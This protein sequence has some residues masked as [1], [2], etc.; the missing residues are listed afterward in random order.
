MVFV[1]KLRRSTSLAAAALLIVASAVPLLS[2]QTAG[3]YTLL[4]E[5]EIKMGTSQ[6]GVV[7]E[8]G[9]RVDFVLTEDVNNLE[10]VVVTF[11]EESP[12]IGEEDC[13]VPAGFDLDGASVTGADE[14]DVDL[15]SFTSDFVNVSNGGSDE[16]TLVLHDDTGVAVDNGDVVTFTIEN[17]NNPTALG[18]FFARIMVYDDDTRALAYNDPGDTESPTLAGGIALST[19][20]V[21][22]I[23]SKVQERL[24][25]CIH[26]NTSPANNPSDCSAPVDP[27]VLGDE[28]GVLSAVDPT[29]SDEA[30]FGITTNA[31]AGATVR[32]KGATLDSGSFTIDPI[33]DTA[34]TSNEGSEQF[35][36]C[37]HELGSPGL[38]ATA[39]YDSSDCSGVT[40][41]Q[42]QGNDNGASFAFDTAQ[43][44]SAYGSSI[45]TKDA[46]QW[47][48][49]VLVFL[50]NISEVTEPGIYTTTLDFIATGRY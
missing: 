4:G 39:P 13:A 37:V 27:V 41:G 15:T 23:E 31:S 36:L 9:Y 7:D 47:S 22:T 49:G 6:T 20:D 34:A 50:G 35:G 38:S 30:R 32:M 45:A 11:C 33:G 29:I 16:N 26:T 8:D 18:T 42:G 2:V 28:N 24:E 25:F 10:G 17:V 1:D 3:A 12:I 19:A 44:E 40:A 21:I 46:G 43:T 5:R 14:G 48:T